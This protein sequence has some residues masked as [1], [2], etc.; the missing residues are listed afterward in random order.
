MPKTMLSQLKPPHMTD[1]QLDI[2][3]K[4]APEDSEKINA[5]IYYENNG[6]HQSRPYKQV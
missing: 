6:P 4:N 5:Y 2:L 1:K 3:R